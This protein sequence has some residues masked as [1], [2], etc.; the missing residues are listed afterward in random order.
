MKTL[1]P[2]DFS[3]LEAGISEFRVK[4]E[5]SI[6]PPGDP[7]SVLC[8]KQMFLALISTTEQGRRATSQPLCDE[9]QRKS[10]CWFR[11]KAFLRQ[12]GAQ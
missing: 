12:T 8:T 6:K 2:V 4:L 7:E 11:Q 1:V 3:D 5:R 9:L 10:V